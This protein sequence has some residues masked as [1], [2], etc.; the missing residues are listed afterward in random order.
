M[1]DNELNHEY[2]MRHA[3]GLAKRA[4]EEGEVPVGAV[5]VHNNQVIGEG[6]NRPIGRHDPTA[7]AE[8]MA[9]RQGGL[10]L[11]NYRLTDTTLY[12]TLEPCVMCAGAMV[13]SRIGTLVFGA[14]DAKTGAAGSLM[15][16]L[17]HP[18]MNHRVE[19]VEGI[20]SESCAAM[21]SDFF[22]QRRAEKKALKKAADPA[23]GDQ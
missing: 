23:A 4:W 16:V 19:I 17:H 3:L 8:I 21:L 15:D 12:V 1:S 18:G 22:R 20:L 10:V 13:H 14:R 9:L 2:W 5:L 7:H 6:W 11:Q